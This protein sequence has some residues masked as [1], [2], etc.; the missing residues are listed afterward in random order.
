MV[1]STWDRLPLLTPEVEEVVLDAVVQKAQA[2]D[3]RVLAVGAVP[4]HLHLLVDMSPNVSVADLA[5]GVKGTS[6]RVAGRATAPKVFRWQ[7]GYFAQTI[8]PDDADAVVRYIGRQK[9][10]HRQGLPP[11]MDLMEPLSN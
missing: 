6:S 10:H 8:S 4:D 3:C 1:W 7:G 11:E 9:E 5:K 2:L